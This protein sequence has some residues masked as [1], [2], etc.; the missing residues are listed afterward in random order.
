MSAVSF[1]QR[2]LSSI[3]K[4]AKDF[5]STFVEYEYLLHSSKFTVQPYYIISTME[6][7][8]KHL[9]GVVSELSPYEFF[10][11]CI[12]ETIVESDI[13]FVFEKPNGTFEDVKD[14]VRKKIKAL[15]YI[16]NIFCVGL[17]GEENF[18]KGKVSCAIAT[19]DNKITLGFEERI[20]SRPKTLLRGN[21]IKNPVNIDFILRRKKGEKHFDTIMQGDISSVFTKQF[22]LRKSWKH[23]KHIVIET[24]NILEL[25]ED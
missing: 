17:I 11:K 16:E 6:S 5:Q 23:I 21:E 2:V 1:K 18:I 14:T 25:N 22:E 7:N 3:I 24:I 8:Y 15:P 4:H 20:F 10:S 13:D 12:A 9:T 19:S